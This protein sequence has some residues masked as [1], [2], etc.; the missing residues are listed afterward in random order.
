MTLCTTFVC[1]KGVCRILFKT[2]HYLSLQHHGVAVRRSAICHF[3]A[4]LA[5]SP[6]P[7]S[8][9]FS[10]R[11]IVFHHSDS[12]KNCHTIVISGPIP[13]CRL[14]PVGSRSGSTPSLYTPWS[15]PHELGVAKI[16]REMPF[17]ITF[18]QGEYCRAK[19]HGD[20]RNVPYRRN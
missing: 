9:F 6:E 17:Y 10:P 20:S 5:V 11:S 15:T 3:L 13:Y 16:G 8:I 2:L 1:T 4:P 18:R 14:W 19:T 7:G 12:P